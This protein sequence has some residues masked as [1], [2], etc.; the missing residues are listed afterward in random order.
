VIA[1]T[2]SSVAPGDFAWSN[3]GN[4]TVDDTSVADCQDLQ[5]PNDSEYLVATN[6]GLAI[7]DT[8]TIDGIIVWYL[9][10]QSDLAHCIL[11]DVV[12]RKAGASVGLDHGPN[13]SVTL[14]GGQGE[15]SRGGASDMWSLEGTLTPAYCNASDFGYAFRVDSIGGVDIEVCYCDYMKIEVFYTEE[16]PPGSAR[17]RSRVRI[18]R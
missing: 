6:F 2:G 12:L 15:E 5:P 16:L 7:P 3:P 18:N 13:T 1:G 10:Y 14:E 17:I 4:I 8:A 9:L 11:R